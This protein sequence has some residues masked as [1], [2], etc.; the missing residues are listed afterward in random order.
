MINFTPIPIL[1]KIGNFTVYSFGLFVA[2]GG[3]IAILLSLKEAKKRN[4][5]QEKVLGIL[6]F[7]MVGALIGARILYIIQNPSQFNF[8]W[9]Y[10][11]LSEG[12]LNG[13]GTLIGGTLFAFLYIKISK[14]S[15]G[16]FGKLMDVIAPYLVLAFAIGRI[17]CFLRGCCFGLPTNLP[18]GIVYPA[19]SLAVQAGLNTAVHPTQLYHSILDFIIFFIL[20]K[21]GNKKH[22]LQKNNVK[23]KY[24]FFS[25]G[26]SIFLLF[27]MLYSSERFIVDFFRYH[28]ASEYVSILT[29]TQLIYAAI[30][31]AAFVMSE[32]LAK[33]TCSIRSISDHPKNKRGGAL[34]F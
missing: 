26:G 4:I 18:W 19:E 24:R 31:I 7:T 2:L 28:P 32:M 33:T 21:L 22:N 12:G 27:L 25:I 10:I 9:D 3:L 13:A 6:L 34:F 15:M 29:V 5:E 8:F 23:S 17:G 30:F 11:N 14:M 1:F 20:L 16:E